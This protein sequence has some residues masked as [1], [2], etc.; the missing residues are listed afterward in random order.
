MKYF[1]YKEELGINDKWLMLIGIPLIGFLVP[2]IFFDLNEELSPVFFVVKFIHSCFYA[3]FYWLVLRYTFIKLRRKYPGTKQVQRRI[4]LQFLVAIGLIILVEAFSYFLGICLDS[5]G[6]AYMPPPLIQLNTLS[7]VLCI[8]V[9]AIYESVYFFS[10]YQDSIIEQ[11]RLKRANIRSELDTLRNQVNPHFLFNSLNT[12]ASIIPE[13]PKLAIEFV[14]KLSK[15]YRNI[16]EIRN[17]K[18]IPLKRELDTLKSYI[19]LLELRFRDKLNI[20]I[21]IEDA[22]SDY[23]IPLTLQILIENAVKHNIVSASKPLQISIDMDQDYVL[24][25]NNLQRKNQNTSST[26]VGLQNIKERYSLLTN[27]EVFIEE[28]T[29]EFIVKLPR[30]QTSAL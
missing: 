6:S 20:S 26:K 22:N 27:Q 14:Q 4:A 25:R 21:N 1:E 18:M 13:D 17:E 16:L 19:F 10:K 11:E 8:S 7:F 2:F 15:A 3:A 12:L 24:V 5:M 28:T 30:I 9:G 23:V 29:D